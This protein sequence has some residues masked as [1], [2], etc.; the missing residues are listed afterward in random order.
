MTTSVQL[1]PG[2]RVR[3]PSRKLGTVTGWT[4][5]DA[6]HDFQLVPSIQWDAGTASTYRQYERLELL[7]HK[8]LSLLG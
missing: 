2:T 4:S 1:T 6:R 7:P 8:Q 3:T 5:D